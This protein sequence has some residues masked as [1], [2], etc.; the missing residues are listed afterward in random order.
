MRISRVGF[1]L[2][3]PLFGTGLSPSPCRCMFIRDRSIIFTWK[4]HRP[5]SV[6]S[7]CDISSI[8]LL[9]NL[10][11]IFVSLSQVDGLYFVCNIDD[12]KF[13]A[14]MIQHIPL[15]LRARYVFC[16]APIN[17]NLP[18]VCTSLL[19]VSMD[20]LY[21]KLFSVHSYLLFLINFCLGFFSSP[22]SSAGMSRL[23]FSGF[24]SMSAGRLPLRKP[25]KI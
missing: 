14:D 23:P 5:V 7:S 8:C 2:D 10:Q 24:V 11:D 3:D 15:N 13:V 6:F 18:F 16:T 1:P 21:Q 25:S 17:R 19:K 4:S 20:F 12:F 9:S 22:V